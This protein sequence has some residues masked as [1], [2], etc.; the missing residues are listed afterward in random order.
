M[1][2]MAERRN[3]CIRSCVQGRHRDEVCH[4]ARRLRYAPFPLLPCSVDRPVF[5]GTAVGIGAVCSPL[6][7]TQFAQLS[8]W[9][10]HYLVLLGIAISNVLVLAAVFRFKDQEGAYMHVSPPPPS[11]MQRFIFRD[12]ACLAEIGQMPDRGSGSD[13]NKYKQI[14]GLRALHLMAMFIL[15]YVGIEVTLGGTLI[16]HPASGGG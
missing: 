2:S 10:F 3:E 9:S 6:I 12:S 8:H 1:I 11:L 16:T 7:A 4:L 5:A 14:F 13:A 15:L